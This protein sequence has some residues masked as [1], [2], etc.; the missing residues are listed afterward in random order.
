M[1]V[2]GEEFMSAIPEHELAA[3]RALSGYDKMLEMDRIMKQYGID[4]VRLLALLQGNSNQP[5]Q[6]AAPPF[7]AETKFVENIPNPAN[8][9]DKSNFRFD[10]DPS[11]E[12]AKRRSE[13]TQAVACPAC[14]G[15]LGIPDI[16]PIKVTCPQCLQET[17][18][19]S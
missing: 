15:T 18:F 17:V 8:V 19:T 3:L 1:S 7:V 9:L 16:R 11:P 2:L 6:A 12:A 10:Y 5:A 14:G 4:E 13:I